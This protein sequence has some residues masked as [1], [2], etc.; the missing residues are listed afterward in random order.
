MIRKFKLLKEIPGSY[1]R[2]GSILVLGGK[3]HKDMDYFFKPVSEEYDP[4]TRPDLWEEVKEEKVNKTDTYKL[5]KE[6]PGSPELGTTVDKRGGF[7]YFNSKNP[8][9]NNTESEYNIENY[10]E[11][12]QKVKEKKVLF[13]CEDGV[14]IFEGDM[15]YYIYL[16]GFY[17]IEKIGRPLEK[18]DVR[19]KNYKYFSKKEKA[20]DWIYNHKPKFSFADIEK[21]FFKSREFSS[22]RGEVIIFE[23]FKNYLEKNC[24]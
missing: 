6:Y 15:P 9:I 3:T 22:D 21:A 20:E 16:N 4:A 5:I 24:L 23:N 18:S 11:F 13:T 17:I 10:P 14:D 8:T 7:V 19:I 12:W 2:V 1:M